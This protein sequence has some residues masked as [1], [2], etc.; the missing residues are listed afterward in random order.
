[1]KFPFLRAVLSLI[2]ASCPLANANILI[3]PTFESSI[4]WNPMAQKIEI[5]IDQA[6]SNIESFIANPI[7][8]SIDFENRNNGLGQ[9][10]T[11]VQDLSYSRYRSDLADNQE[12]SS[13]DKLALASLPKASNNPVNGNADVV[14]TLPNLR[15]IG[16][17]ALGNNDGA[18]DSSISLN[19]SEMNLSRTGPQDPNKYDLEAETTH[20][21]DE[22]LGIGGSG[23]VLSLSG[24]TVPT[25]AVGS[26]DLFRFASPGVRSFT[27]SATATAYFSIDSGTTNL[28]NFNDGNG[29]SDFGDWATGQI[30][31][32]QDAFG[33]PG[34][35][36][37]LGSNE[38]TALDVVGYNL[39]SVPEP[40]ISALLLSGLIAIGIGSRDVKK[41][42]GSHQGHEGHRGNIKV[43]RTQS[44]PNFSL[45]LKII[46][47]DLRDLCVSQF[48][49]SGGKGW[50]LRLRT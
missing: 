30:P 34:V 29:S 25:G 14:L 7:T 39:V 8:V 16:E 1:V 5:G 47:C 17:T 45:S 31:Q 38:L 13:N 46:L 15:A 24:P 37:N 48:P 23:S 6:I 42:R 21:I 40:G 10:S 32:V 22:A 35:D 2:A 12:L 50:S 3:K 26:L 49:H 4:T 9:S 36:V 44:A 19:F 18:F 27:T 28:T 43:V 20:E 33:S 11:L 41:L